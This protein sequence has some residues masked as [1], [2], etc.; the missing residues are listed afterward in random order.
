M[1]YKDSTIKILAEICRVL[2]GGVFIFSGIV[3]AVDPAGFAI[4]ME[5][6]LHAFG[7]YSFDSLSILLSFTLCAFEFALGVCMLM[8]VYRKFTSILVVIF[9]AFMTPLTLYLAIFN[10]VSDCGCFGDAVVIS[11]WQTFWKNLVLLA[12]SIVVLKNNYRLLQVYTI[13]AY[14]FVAIFSYLFCVGFAYQNYYHLPIIDF[15]PYK[16]GTNI[17]EQMEVPEG[18]PEDEYRYTFIYEKDGKTQEFSLEDY[19]AHDSTWTFVDA[20]TELISEGY[21][22]EIADFHLYNLADEEVTDDIL[23]HNGP[24]LLLISPRLEKADD[25]RINQIN[26]LYDYA[27]DNGILFYCVTGSAPEAMKYWEDVTGAEY[28]FLLADDTLLKTIIRANPGLVLLDKG[29]ILMKWHY[30]DI[31]DEELI[32]E[33]LNSYLN[34]KVNE[35]SKQR[36]R[37]RTNLFTFSVPL[38]IVLGYDFLRNRRRK[39][40]N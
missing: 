23:Y 19:P 3:K 14:W 7:L 22:P 2:L 15:R 25:E 6:Y 17:P 27:L 4:K 39:K 33:E 24:V 10:P 30:K 8:G 5:D 11:N 40:D 9:M 20:K 35:K 36:G 28:P 38:L 34:G 18:A 26:N 29:I 16:I 32:N 31:P 1:G 37:L 13:K 21:H 12:A